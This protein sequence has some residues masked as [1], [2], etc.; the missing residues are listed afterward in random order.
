MVPPVLPPIDFPIDLPSSDASVVDIFL[1]IFP[2]TPSINVGVAA[3]CVI[4]SFSVIRS[5]RISFALSRS[6]GALYFI[7]RDDTE[8]SHPSSHSVRVS[9]RDSGGAI[10]VLASGVGIHFSSSTVTSASPI[11]RMRSS[12]SI[13]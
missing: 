6:I 1:V 5:V 10:I 3:F 9:M 4:W 12:S 11:P 13:L 7:A 2:P 8:R